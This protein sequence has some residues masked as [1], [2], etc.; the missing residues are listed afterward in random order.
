MR[1]SLLSRDL[2]PVCH[3]GVVG[4]RIL[5]HQVSQRLGGI[6]V[7]LLS[8]RAVPAASGVKILR[9]PLAIGVEITHAVLRR[10]IAALGK[11][12]PELEG[13]PKI[14]ASDGGPAII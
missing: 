12:L 13:C 1:A 6:T 9:H 8:A 4:R 3:R 7:A 5:R 11:R 10:S 14:T 2:V